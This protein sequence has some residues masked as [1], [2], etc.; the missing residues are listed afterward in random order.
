VVVDGKF[1]R[2]GSAKFFPKGVTY[3]PFTP[4]SAAEFFPDYERTRSDFDLIR[5]LGANL[6]RVYT[7]PPRWLLNLALEKGI[8]VLVDVPWNKHLCFLDSEEYLAEARGAVRKAAIACKDHSAVFAI[9]VV[10]EVPPDIV[11]WS[12]TK[13][14]ST[15]ID[16]LV[17][18]VREVDSAILCTFGNFPSTEFLHPEE[19]DFLC[20]NVYL[21][22]Q[23]P[24]ENYLA[25]LQMLAETKPLMI[26]E[27]GVDTLREGE[28]RQSEILAWKIESACRFGL[29]GLVVYSFSDEW[30]KDGRLVADW[31][32]GLTTADRQKKLSFDVVQRAFSVAPYFRLQAE[33]KVSVV[34]ASYNGAATLR[35]CLQSL[36]N[37]NY[38]AYEVI[39]V[40]DGSTDNTQE[41]AADFPYI[42]SLRH[43]RNQGL[44]VARNTG[45]EAAKGDIVAFTDSD[46][47]ADAD[48]L[49]YLVGDLLK[50]GYTG[51]GGHNFLPP[52]DSATAASVMVSPGGPAHVMLTDRLAEHL[53]G[54]NMAFYK[55]ALQSVG[56]F[57]PMFRRA[58]DDVDICW[59]LQQRG[60]RLGFSP[61]GFVWHYRRNTIQA[62][63]KQQSGYGEAE[64][65]LERRHPENFNGFGGSVWH[66]R[67]YSAAKIGVHT[68]PPIIYHGIFG[69]APFQS[70]YTPNPGL[71][72][73]VVTSIEYHVIV[74]LPLL[75]LGSV[76]PYIGTLG[77]GSLLFSLGMC[78]AAGAQAEI[79][80]NKRRVWSR[81]LVA[82]LFFLQPIVRGWA[83]NRGHFLGNRTPLSARE[84]LESLSLEARRERT[85][86]LLYWSEKGFDRMAYL[87]RLLERLDAG[88]WQNKP[89][90]GWS[91]FDVEV[92]GSRWATLRLVTATEY[93][94]GGRQML[95]CRLNTAWS[96]LGRTAFWVAAGLALVVIGFSSRFAGAWVWLLLLL[97]PPIAWRLNVAERDLRR[98]I[99]AFLDERAKEFQLVRV[100][101]ELRE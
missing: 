27:F 81:P 58:G 22:E 9:S 99:V 90:A 68:R 17:Q 50:S 73:V 76:L 20:F 84:T 71:T 32:F 7:I 92:Y 8:R 70:I 47:R 59:R 31:A 34:V 44:S 57:D 88:G 91:P 29:A 66:G 97:L 43:A 26:G 10:N 30:Y 36:R 98:V 19:I 39:L 56:G 14:V 101:S 93:H 13:R 12:G 24:F 63:L 89:D 79:P 45:I 69:S 6:I 52:D 46:C 33:P 28:V 55:W 72:L 87:A 37:L 2:L 75:V 82:L 15:F 86:E 54:C 42:R 1:F 53:P 21:H 61:G 60:Y 94:R 48:W 78:A 51:I 67:I 49:Y 64:A 62:Y 65:M 96:F 38:P 18:V 35:T 5:E 85:D 80:L 4:N 25:R 23:V 40:D 16:E 3:G 77:V 41:I 83:R 74:T 100:D 11:R 95:R